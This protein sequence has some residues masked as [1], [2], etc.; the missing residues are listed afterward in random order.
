MIL[1][2]MLKDSD[3]AMAK[4]VETRA[5]LI[6]G[7]YHI[8]QTKSRR[9]NIIDFFACYLSG[10]TYV[11]LRHDIHPNGLNEIIKIIESNSLE[12]IQAIWSTSGTTGESKLVCHKRESIEWAVLQS[13]KNWGYTKDDFVYCSELPNSTAILMLTLPSILVGANRVLK[14]FNQ[15]DIRKQNFTMIGW[16]PEVVDM[17][18][19]DHSFE[20][21]RVTMGASEIKQRHV[22][23][24][25][26][27]DKWWASWSMTEVLMPG[28]IGVNSL[29]MKPYDGYEVK[30]NEKSEL[31][32]KGPGLMLGYLGQDRIG[33][34]FN[35]SDIWEKVDGGYRF[36]RR[37]RGTVWHL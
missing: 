26:N 27:V 14:K 35:T 30:L 24:L 18:D 32:I 15:D 37:T 3:P 4:E 23:K 1:F 7:D 19:D 20:G 17:L 28:M 10:V 31:L 2:N 36:V 16:V 5:S 8:S 9:Q 29:V 25:N 21:T 33:E 22:D 34:W 13:I 12:G 11:P 6:D